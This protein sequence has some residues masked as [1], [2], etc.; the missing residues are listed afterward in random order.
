[1]G[2]YGQLETI[3]SADETRADIRETMR[4]WRAVQDFEMLPNLR[5]DPTAAI[6]F[7]VD[8]AKKTLRCSRFEEYRNNIRAIY[9]TLEALRLAHE[10]GIL[11]ELAEAATAF[12]P[13]PSGPVKRPWYEVLGLMPNADAESVEAMYRHLARKRHPDA[14]GSDDE[15]SELNAA[16]ETFKALA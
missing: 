8:G 9:L 16:L 7:W 6:E 2:Q 11:R 14:G 3:K 1:M 10:R 13:A 12:L 15:M 4:K 5:P